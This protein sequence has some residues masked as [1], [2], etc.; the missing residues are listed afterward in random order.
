MHLWAIR[1]PAW[2]QAE[3][4]LHRAGELGHAEALFREAEA[5][6]ME[7]QPNLP[8]LYSLRGYLYCDLLIARGRYAEATARAGWA[9]EAYRAASRDAS[10]AF[11]SII[12]SGAR[13]AGRNPAFS[14][15]RRRTA[16]SLAQVTCTCA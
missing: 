6:Q 16:H 13:G 10:V 5:L 1:A 14:P 7:K 15:R 3:A 11:R 2:Q 12:H 4:L 9:I 8:R